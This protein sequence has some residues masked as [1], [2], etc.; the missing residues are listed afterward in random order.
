MTGTQHRANERDRDE[1]TCLRKAGARTRTMS[2]STPRR[3]NLKRDGVAEHDEPPRRQR[4]RDGASSLKEKYGGNGRC[5]SAWGP[6][7]QTTCSR[8]RWRMG[9]DESIPA[10]RPR[11]RR[12]R[13]PGHRLIPLAKGGREDRRLRPAASAG[14][15]P[16]TARPLR[17]APATAAFLGIPQVTLCGERR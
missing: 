17:P 1:N 13:H 10:L 6:R 3:G 8:R 7:R 4:S 14:A 9:C 16:P 12:R 5:R 11:S 15:T 2:S